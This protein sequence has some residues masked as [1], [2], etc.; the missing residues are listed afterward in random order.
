M[1]SES[2]MHHV[3]Y[4]TVQDVHT[5]RAVTYPVQQQP[6][7]I[8]RSAS[9]L[10]VLLFLISCDA[11]LHGRRA[12]PIRKS[13]GRRSG[14]TGGQ[15]VDERRTGAEAG[16]HRLHRT[17]AAQGAG[18]GEPVP[19]RTWYTVA[20]RD[21]SGRSCTDQYR[22]G[23]GRRQESNVLEGREIAGRWHLI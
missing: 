21:G 14:G 2:R 18:V 9:L 10:T 5:Y 20:A 22:R 6:G 16:L 13:W 1:I 8:P 4:C 19:Y 15:R 12:R 7:V 17:A 3:P 11:A 23:L